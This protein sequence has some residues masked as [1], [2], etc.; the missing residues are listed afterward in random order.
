MAGQNPMK[1]NTNSPTID[2]CRNEQLAAAAWLEENGWDHKESRGAWM[3]VYD[4]FAEEFLMEE[5][6][7][8]A[9][10]KRPVA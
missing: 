6:I 7:S 4:N 5:E 9:N 10:R 1:P 2:H 8:N 3:G